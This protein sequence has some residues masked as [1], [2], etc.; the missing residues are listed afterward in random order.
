VS[1]TA[2]TVAVKDHETGDTESQDVPLHDYL[3]LVTGDCYVANIQAHANG[4]HVIT[5]KG[6]KGTRP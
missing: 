3:L 1:S 2:I 4:T 5:I 6:R